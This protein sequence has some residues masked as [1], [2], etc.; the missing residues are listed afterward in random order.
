MSDVVS[1][2]ISYFLL[3]SSQSLT[4]TVTD[5]A[6][7]E[8]KSLLPRGELCA[9]DGPF[10][11]KFNLCNSCI[12]T[13]SS[14][15]WE[16]GNA[17]RQYIEPSFGDIVQQCI[18]VG[19]TVTLSLDLPV[20]T[21]VQA[22][23]SIIPLP[24]GTGE[25]TGTE[26]LTG[27]EVAPVFT[28]AP[29]MLPIPGIPTTSATGTSSIEASWLI[30]SMATETNTYTLLTGQTTTVTELMIA[31]VTRADWT[32]WSSGN[33]PAR[34]TGERKTITSI[35][36]NVQLVT[37]TDSNGVAA[38]SKGFGTITTTSLSPTGASVSGSKSVA[39][40]VWA[41]MA[42]AIAIVVGTLVASFVLVKRKRSKRAKH[43][44][45]SSGSTPELPGTTGTG[46]RT[47]L[48]SETSSAELHTDKILPTEL[49]S[50][51]APVEMDTEIR[52]E[53]PTDYNKEREI[54]EEAMTPLSTC[55]DTPRIP[56]S[57]LEE[58]NLD[59]Q[60][61]DEQKVLVTPGLNLRNKETPQTQP[62]P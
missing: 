1:C 33:R 20:T 39:G 32:G 43:Q 60:I 37:P 51:V 45:S 38:V 30:T 34:V 9:A 25:V 10:I 55:T 27:T 11:S 22:I 49:D 14:N 16:Y 7:L 31:T 28:T 57:P 41:V 29:Y 13:E 12:Q 26:K 50:K 36:T 21:T 52:F 47:E 6:F 4:Q 23:V 19:T 5:A 61:P 59:Q 58:Q 54:S 3:I 35:P 15:A 42:V 18:G 2:Q 44:R 56:V 17:Y 62:K 40:W 46:S 24:T 53:L 8:S 48:D